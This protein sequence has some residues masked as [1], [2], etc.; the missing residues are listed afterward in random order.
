MERMILDWRFASLLSREGITPYRLHKYLARHDVSRT[1]VYRWA[2][3]PPG[4]LDLELVGHVLEALREATGKQYVLSD[5]IDFVSGGEESV[6]AWRRLIGAWDHPS[7]PED[8]S[9]NVDRYLDEDLSADV[10]G[11]E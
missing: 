3:E 1:T 11:V 5:I 6:P 7:A 9:S 10:D 4:S 2:K 8:G